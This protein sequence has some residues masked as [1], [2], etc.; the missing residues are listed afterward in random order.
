MIIWTTCPSLV[1]HHKSTTTVN[2]IKY[3]RSC[4][5]SVSVKAKK[6]IVLSQISISG[7]FLY[8]VIFVSGKQR[9]KQLSELSC[10]ELKI[11]HIQANLMW[12]KTGICIAKGLLCYWVQKKKKKLKKATTDA[13]T[14]NLF[15]RGEEAA[16]YSLWQCLEV[17]KIS[18]VCISTLSFV[19]MTVLKMFF[20]RREFR[21]EVD[22]VARFV[23]ALCYSLC[24][25]RNKQAA[26]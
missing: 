7:I 25:L 6:N 5:L 16:F 3:S 26:Q 9:W 22:I 15:P 4:G 20:F 21:D 11:G 8:V 24:K 2:C 23:V 17:V 10:H 14:W 13:A 1:S 19:V 18:S 12:K